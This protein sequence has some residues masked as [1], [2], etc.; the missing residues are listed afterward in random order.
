MK[1]RKPKGKRRIIIKPA[2]RLFRNVRQANTIF[3]AGY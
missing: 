2:L 3:L 1:R